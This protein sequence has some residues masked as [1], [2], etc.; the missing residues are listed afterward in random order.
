MPLCLISD[1][2][3]EA[4]AYDFGTLGLCRKVESDLL[5]LMPVQID[6]HI[7]NRMPRLVEARH[8]HPEFLIRYGGD[9]V[10]IVAVIML[11][12]NLVRRVVSKRID[13]TL[14]GIAMVAPVITILHELTDVDLAGIIAS[15][16]E[17]KEIAQPRA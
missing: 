9:T 2:Y 6:R 12:G 3:D 11:H 16:S 13:H 4:P 7:I 8:A 17:V 15:W 10:L 5:E 14:H 1:R